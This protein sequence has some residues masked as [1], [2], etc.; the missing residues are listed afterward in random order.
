[1]KITL[2]FRRADNRRWTKYT[3]IEMLRDPEAPAA[4]NEK[5]DQLIDRGGQLKIDDPEIDG[6]KVEISG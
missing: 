5:I 2:L 4:I 1:M 3:S 6:F